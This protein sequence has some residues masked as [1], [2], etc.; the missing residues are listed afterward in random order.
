MFI[1]AAQAQDTVTKMGGA[2][3]P[4]FQI[5]PFILVF[6][7]MYFLIIRP[8]R[9]RARQ[10]QEMIAALQEGDV[11][12]TNGGLIGKV[13]K[14]LNTNEIQI[15]L[16]EGVR[17]RVVRMTL[18]EVRPKGG[19][20]GKVERAG[21][22]SEKHE[23][24]KKGPKE[25]RNKKGTAEESAVEREGEKQTSPLSEEESGREEGSEEKK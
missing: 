4:F 10:H 14:L 11:V 15:E 3:D 17:V 8:Q 24:T 5:F 13:T 9:Q 16:A 25:E 22:V 7:I 12:V 21:T 23:K 20:P 19:V 1:T 18:Q 2:L 6:A